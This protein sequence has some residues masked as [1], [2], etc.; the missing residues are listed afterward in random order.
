MPPPHLVL[1]IEDNA[2]NFR[3]IQSLL[4]SRK[5]I[6]LLGATCGRDG[7]KLTRERHPDLILLDL[8]L[9]DINGEEVLRQLRLAPATESIP[10]IVLS[11]FALPFQVAKLKA[12]GIEHYLTKPLDLA[13]VL[14]V[15]DDQLHIR[16]QGCH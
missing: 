16:Q 13:E 11:A 7:L 1:Y 2:S 12:A 14:R 3:L 8:Q 5:D 10:V 15:V 4:S 6:E 9:P